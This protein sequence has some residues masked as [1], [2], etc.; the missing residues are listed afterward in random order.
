ML[1]FTSCKEYDFSELIER[2]GWDLLFLWKLWALRFYVHWL[3]TR[4]CS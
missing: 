3:P 2:N 1:S 4:L